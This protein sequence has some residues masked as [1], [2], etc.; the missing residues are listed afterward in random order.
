MPKN[1]IRLLLILAILIGGYYFAQQQGVFGQEEAKI[2]TEFNTLQGNAQEQ[3]STISDRAK[4][5]GE[6]AKNVFSTGIQVDESQP[7][8]QE[9][10]IEYGQYLYCKQVVEGYEA[11]QQ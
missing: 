3:F 5:L 2:Q 9:K 1:L 7:S 8:I 11:N 6:Q 10:A 4:V